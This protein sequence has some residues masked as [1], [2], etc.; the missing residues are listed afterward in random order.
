M[1]QKGQVEIF[2]MV[3]VE[4]FNSEVKHPTSKKRKVPSNSSISQLDPFLES[5]NII[6]VGG[7]LRKST[8]TEAE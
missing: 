4:S 6:R 1:I 8:P 5:D 2:R 3:Q 7:R